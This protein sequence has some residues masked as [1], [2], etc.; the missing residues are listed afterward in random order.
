MAEPSTPDNAGR[1]LVKHLADYTTVVAV[2]AGT[3]I[4]SSSLIGLTTSGTACLG[5]P[6]TLGLAVASQH[7]RLDGTDGAF[8]KTASHYARATLVGSGVLG[9]SYGAAVGLL[10]ALGIVCDSA[11]LR[12]LTVSGKEVDQGASLMSQRALHVKQLVVSAL[13]LPLGVAIVS[14]WRDGQ[15]VAR[16]VAGGILRPALY[17]AVGNTLVYMLIWRWSSRGK[18]GEK[19]STSSKPAEKGETTV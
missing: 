16:V 4:F 9:A 19:A 14:R 5:T 18:D 2:V 6:V 15:L 7:V 12:A 17:A 13:A 3:T 10:A 11:R 8:W 1:S